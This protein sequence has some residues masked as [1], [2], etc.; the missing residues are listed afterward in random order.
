MNTNL[1]NTSNQQTN[2]KTFLKTKNKYR[3]QI[4][5]QILTECV[6]AF[7]YTEFVRVAVFSQSFVVAVY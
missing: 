1:T 7:K 2:L 3:I 5:V 4:R 6:C